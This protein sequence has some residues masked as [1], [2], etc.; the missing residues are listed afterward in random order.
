MSL[1]PYGSIINLTLKELSNLRAVTL[2]PFLHFDVVVA[3]NVEDLCRFWNLRAFAFGYHWLPDRRVLLLTKEQFFDE[4]YFS[5]LCQLIREKRN[6]PPHVA[7]MIQQRSQQQ[8]IQA[9]LLRVHL[10]VVF[11]HSDDEEIS[12]F[13]QSQPN[14]KPNS[15]RSFV[16]TTDDLGREVS[17]ETLPWN[18]GE[19]ERP[20]FYM[21][22]LIDEPPAY[23]EYGGKQSFLSLEVEEG[24]NALLVP[25]AGP[26]TSS[27]RIVKVGIQS[28]L[29]EAYLPHPAVAD[30]IVPQASFEVLSK[31]YNP[32][33]IYTGQ[34][35]PGEMQRIALTLPTKWQMYQAY[36]QA[37]GYT[38]NASDKMI[39]ATGLLDRAGGLEKAEILRSR[40][41]YNILD[42]LTMRATQ[43]L[44]QE[45]MKQVKKELSAT[46]VSEEEIV[47]IIAASGF[48]PQFQR[49]PK[50]FSEIKS[51]LKKPSERKECLDCLAE[52]VKIKAIQRGLTIVCP[53]C[54]TAIWY[55]LGVL[56][57][58][59]KCLGCLEYF[60]MP[61]REAPQSPMDQSLQYSLNPLTDRAMAQDVLPVI[62]ALLTLRTEHQALTHIVPGMAFKKS[63]ATNTEGDFDFV[64][65]YKHYLYGGECKAGSILG[66]KDIQTARI[67]RQLGFRA[68]FF[69]TIGTFSAESRQLI[70]DFQQELKSEPPTNR[71][72]GVFLLEEQE[73]FE[74][75]LSSDISSL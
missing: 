48:L 57:E 23:R 59:I 45:I 69:V 2:F 41:A 7:E 74:G 8:D 55:D 24:E 14:L 68:F 40:T 46:K 6:Y 60:D 33:L 43:K 54:G 5:L 62:I 36:F 1:D 47:Q 17:E 12:Q 26:S 9:K 15:G 34:I 35:A 11:H 64:Y 51:D 49:K 70:S 53:H 66:A 37:P 3:Q 19:G 25:K 39:Y 21:E 65:V 18:E 58:Q 73:L 31:D 10:D 67:A 44:A 63:G 50:A 22:N 13:L 29:W 56:D 4:K 52:L 72:F 61:L 42:M 16:T 20:L 28:P 32:M 27:T 75:K 30:L 38:V 71:P